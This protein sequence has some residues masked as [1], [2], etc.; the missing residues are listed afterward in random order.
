MTENAEEASLTLSLREGSV[1]LLER[2]AEACEMLGAA[3]AAKVLG[4]QGEARLA[5][6]GVPTADEAKAAR[7]RGAG[8]PRL[9]ISFPD[10]SPFGPETHI[11][12]FLAWADGHTVAEAAGALGLER[13]TYRRRRKRMMELRELEPESR[14]SEV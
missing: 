7:S 12:D 14:L 5:V 10:G 4:T 11:R 2:F 3:D 13:T 6:V 8:R 9:P 1:E